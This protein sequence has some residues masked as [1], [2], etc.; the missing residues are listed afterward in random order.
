MKPTQRKDALRNIGKQKVSYLSIVII[1]FLGVTAF[2]GICYSAA[3]MKQNGSAVYNQQR[4]RD[5]EVI[6]TRLLTADDLTALRDTEGVLDVEPLY[7]TSNVNAYKGDQRE[8]A[9]IIT[10]TERMNLPI[11]RAGRL[12]ETGTECAVEKRLADR[13]GWQVGDVIDWLE[14]TEDTGQYFRAGES[15][16]ITGIVDHPDH[17]NLNVPDTPYLLVSRDAFDHDGLEGC[18]MKALVAVAADEDRFSAAYADA[19]A[20]AADRI[21]GLAPARIAIRD[22]QL[23]EKGRAQIDEFDAVLQELR[24]QMEEERRQLDEDWQQLQKDEQGQADSE[25]ALAQRR[26]ALEQ[27]EAEYAEKQGSFAFLEENRDKAREEID[28]MAPGRWIVLDERGNAGFVQLEAASDNLSSLQMTFSLLF[29]IIG[30]LVIYATI[31]KMVDEQR[32]LVGVTKA[33]GFF[34][35]EVF[36]KYLLFGLSATLLGTVL[37]ILVARFL[38]EGFVLKSYNDYYTVNI[39]QAMLVLRPTWIVVLGGVSLT[40]AAVTFACILLVRMPAIQLL[41]PPVPKGKTTTGRSGKHLLSLYSRLVLLNIRTDIK[42]VLVTVVSVAGCCALVVIGFTLKN[43]VEQCVVNQYT[44]IVRYDGRIR[45]GYQGDIEQ[46][47]QAAGAEY[48]PLYDGNVTYRIQNM[49]MGELYAGDI[50]AIQGM[51]R[52]NDWQT[53]EPLAPTDEGILIQRRIA[54]KYDLTVGSTFEITLGG[55]RTA[56]AQVAGI[57]ENYIG[58]NLVVSPG[59]YESLFGEPPKYNVFFLRFGSAEPEQLLSELKDIIGFEEYT[60]SDEGKAMFKASTSVINIVVGLF[61]FMAA[62]MAGVVLMNLTNIYILQKKRELTVMR[63]NGFT[64]KEV[65]AYVSRETVFTTILGILL[66]LAAGSFVSYR[67][68]RALEQSFMQ[69]ERGVCFPAWLY[70][71]AITA[72]FAVAVNV[73]VLRKVK[74][75]KLTDAA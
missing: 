49:D 44:A 55:T 68:I 26:Q 2:L 47:L 35:R 1:A 46:H 22:A 32:T 74:H 9:T 13:A 10:V 4:Y 17:I 5:L 28:A 60:P 65:I 53:G 23:Q 43:A 57:F 31:S 24:R 62:V 12:P 63:I 72:F 3:A 59:Y 19:V 50:A 40:L 67:I 30:A 20:A 33:L 37:G 34:N 7:V 69:F 52:L 21:E 14:M 15:F 25:A 8:S 38:L 39:S 48:V 45:F 16:T 27:R 56:T 36:A 64:T 70:A 18:C 6:S 61:I 29:V 66:G 42:R 41:Q 51:F 75:L 71:A 54:E 58:R 11:L 73:I